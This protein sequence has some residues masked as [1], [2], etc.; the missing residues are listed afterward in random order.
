M[1]LDPKNKPIVFMLS[2]A[3][4]CLIAAVLAEAFTQ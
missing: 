1:L 2:A 3:L 4:G